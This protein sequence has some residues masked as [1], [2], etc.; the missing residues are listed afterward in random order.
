[1]NGNLR[2]AIAATVAAVSLAGCSG[3]TSSTSS[4]P[5]GSPSMGSN[6]AV[7][8]DM[9]HAVF[10]SVTDLAGQ[11]DVVLVGLVN[12]S[13]SGAETGL[14]TDPSAGNP[15]PGIPHTNYLV[16]VG[17]VYKGLVTPGSQITVVLAG[18]VTDAG[19]VTVDGVPNLTLGQRFVFFLHLG[20]DGEYYP[21]A[22]GAAIATIN[23]DGSFALPG[24]ATGGSALTF[25]ADQL[26]QQPTSVHLVVTTTP[27]TNLDGQLESGQLT[28]VRSTAN[29]GSISGTAL[30]GGS[31]AVFDVKMA[32]GA[33]TGSIQIDNNVYQISAAR[34]VQLQNNAVHLTGSLQY[35][36]QKSHSAPFNLLLT[37]G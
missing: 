32:S 33:V 9:D 3:A 20:T 29:S 19:P 22:G 17:K 15:V 6:Q 35:V 24:E 26:S 37:T 7:K 28:I 13:S 34:I 14:G 11:S 4:R 36:P 21:M 2:L 16:S 30:V 5:G 8:L 31:V 25:S 27:A 18:G 23:P 10:G 1:M 12:S